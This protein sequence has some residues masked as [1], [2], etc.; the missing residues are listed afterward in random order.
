MRIVDAPS[1]WSLFIRLFRTEI[2]PDFTAFVPRVPG[3][4]TGCLSEQ[5]SCL[6][7]SLWDQ[8]VE[9]VATAP[10]DRPTPA[11]LE[12]ILKVMV[13]KLRVIPDVL[14]GN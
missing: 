5:V 8:S 14:H 13:R 3:Q 10:P 11:K 6:S 2:N 1:F 7:G 4:R 12:S 9:Q